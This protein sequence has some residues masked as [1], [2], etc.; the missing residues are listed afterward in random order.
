MGSSSS[1]SA[2]SASAGCSSHHSFIIDRI[3]CCWSLL[4]LLATIFLV[5]N[6]S[7]GANA[8]Q[9]LPVVNGQ[10][11]QWIKP[12]DEELWLRKLCTESNQH[13][14]MKG[15]KS[16]LVGVLLIVFW[17]IFNFFFQSA[18]LLTSK[19]NVNRINKY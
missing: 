2:A 1:A 11:Q 13:E 15:R 14:V 12:L 3:S 7:P 6:Q 5:L 10:Q 18:E 16:P 9:H 4:L 19:K 8:Q 17:T